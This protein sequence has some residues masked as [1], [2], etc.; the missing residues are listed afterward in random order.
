MLRRAIL[1]RDGVEAFRRALASGTTQLVVSPEDLAEV[2]AEAEEAM[3]EAPGPA[4]RADAPR[5]PRAEPQD[6]VEQAVA[7][8][9][10][11][12]LGVPAIGPNESFFA[13]GG[14][15]LLAM[16]IVAQIRTAYQIGFTLRKFFEE[17]TIAGI[18]RAIRTE[19]VA[20]IEAM[21]EDEAVGRTP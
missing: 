2:R 11:G 4:G 12:V 16:R 13:L 19:I 21:S 7:A 14:H 8:L 9:W 10:S 20:E 3:A 15:S 18:A 1:T 6:E 17:P 5:E